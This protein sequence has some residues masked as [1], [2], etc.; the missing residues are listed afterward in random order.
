MLSALIMKLSYEVE[1][2]VIEEEPDGTFI[3]ETKVDVTRLSESYCE[4]IHSYKGLDITLNTGIKISL[5]DI[6][7]IKGAVK[8]MIIYIKIEI[9]TQI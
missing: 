2:D 1:S 9:E 3:L 7:A 6:L 8:N 5:W 4:L